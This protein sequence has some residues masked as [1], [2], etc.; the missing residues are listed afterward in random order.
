MIRKKKNIQIRVAYNCKGIEILFS[1]ISC[2]CIFIFSIDNSFANSLLSDNTYY[3]SPMRRKINGNDTTYFDRIGPAWSFGEDKR[4]KKD[5]RRYRKL[6]YNFARVYPLSTIG[7]ILV[8]KT[9][10]TFACNNYNRIQKRRYVRKLQ[11]ELLHEYEPILR[12]MSMSQGALLIKLVDR[13]VGKSSFYIIKDYKSG[14]AAG[15]WQG[16][17]RIFGQNLKNEYD[18]KGQDSD[19]ED[20]IRIWQRGEFPFL[21]HSLFWEYPPQVKVP[22]RL[23]KT[24]KES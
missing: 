18:A 21:Y 1:V 13:E 15:F 6:V 5:W 4:S 19:V 23:S 12:K 10:S 9:D 22:S 24:K 20:L 3:Q 16:I 2:I 8:D 11:S 14:L 7:K 17:A